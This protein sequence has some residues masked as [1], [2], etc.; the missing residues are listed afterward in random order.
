MVKTP[1]SREG[2]RV[3]TI[4]DNYRQGRDKAQPINRDLVVNILLLRTIGQDYV[5]FMALDDLAKFEQIIEKAIRNTRRL[6]KA[7]LEEEEQRL[8]ARQADWMANRRPAGADAA[9]RGE[10]GNPVDTELRLG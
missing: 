2:G 8:R 9:Q 3:F 10:E 1:A 6:R 7:K 4:M 5:P